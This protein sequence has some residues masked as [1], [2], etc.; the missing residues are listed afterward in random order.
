MVFITF[1]NPELRR[2]KKKEVKSQNATNFSR[3][4]DESYDCKTR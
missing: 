4:Q 3:S 2:K 1:L